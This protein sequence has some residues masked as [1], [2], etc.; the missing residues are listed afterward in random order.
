MSAG[1][2][3]SF[4]R[5]TSSTASSPATPETPAAFMGRPWQRLLPLSAPPS[6][7]IPAGRR[8]DQTRVEYQERRDQK[9]RDGQMTRDA[10]KSTR[11]ERSVARG[12]HRAGGRRRPG[13]S[14]VK[15]DL[16]ITQRA[17]FREGSKKEG[18]LV[19]IQVLDLVIA[20]VFKS[21]MLPLT[22]LLLCRRLLTNVGQSRVCQHE[23]EAG[24][25]LA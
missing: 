9:T 17:A 15:D 24:L 14:E 23:N 11:T 18:Q 13:S 6:T 4:S 16:G 3:S 8:D 7:R 20:F 10:L 19:A 5:L 21:E 1:F 25:S 2:H 12:C 22:P